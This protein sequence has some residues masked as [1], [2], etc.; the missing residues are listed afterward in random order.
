MTKDMSMRLHR[1]FNIVLCAFILL[2]GALLSAGCLYIYFG[3]GEYTRET[4][5][6]VFAYMAVP[7]WVCLALI[8]AGWVWEIVSP[9]KAKKEKPLRDNANIRK[10]LLLKKDLEGC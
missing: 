1:I 8:V 2:S 10:K 5:A 9:L 7:V 3:V 4:V 6:G